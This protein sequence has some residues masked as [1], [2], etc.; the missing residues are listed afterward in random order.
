MIPV[1]SAYLPARIG[2]AK[3]WC[4]LDSGSEIRSLIPDRCITTEPILP[5][6]QSM[7]AANGTEVDVCGE[8]VVD[9]TV[10]TSRFT[11]SDRVDEVMLGMDWLTQTQAVWNLKHRVVVLHGKEFQ[12][13]VARPIWSVR[14][15]VVQNDVVIP[16][17]TQGNVV[18][19]TAASES[20]ELFPG[21]RVARTLVRDAANDVL[22]P[23]LNATNK[24]VKLP[25]GTPLAPPEPVEL[26][27]ECQ[28]KS[29]RPDTYHVDSLVDDAH[30]SLSPLERQQLA[31]LL[32]R[33]SDVFSSG[34][35][36]L[37]RTDAVVH[38]IDTGNANPVRQTLRPAEVRV[39]P[40]LHRVRPRGVHGPEEA[41]GGAKLA[42]P[43]KQKRFDIDHV[44]TSPYKPS[45]N[46]LIERFHRTLNEISG[47]VV[48][49]AQR[50]WDEWIHYAVATYRATVHE[51]TGY[52]P[53]FIVFGREN[54]LPV[55]LHTRHT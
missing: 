25:P 18:A 1:G 27:D 24:E 11:V 28:Q 6:C 14:R 9:G 45:T 48:D 47:K 44:S 8:A 42:D 10:I 41:R 3:T 31:R 34:D 5:N 16:P 15:V 35:G 7:L 17:N 26:P 19:R 54:A 43:Q 50:N 37:G 53:N 2:G 29:I 30:E 46:G 55:D 20:T 33:Y 32:S 23:F 52:S 39:L 49:R 13:Y 40:W 51:V 4:L 36:D 38:R 12:L 22:L 21:V